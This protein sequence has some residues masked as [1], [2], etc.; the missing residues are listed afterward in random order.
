MKL[1]KYIKK[2]LLWIN[3]LLAVAILI[4][5]LA[6]FISPSRI[7]QIAFFGLA[8]PVLLLLNIGCI[9]FWSWKKKIF[10]LISLIVILAGWANVGRYLQIRI[11]N[12]SPESGKVVR[13]L[14]YNVRVFNRFILKEEFSLLDSVLWF[15]YEQGTEI[16]CL[17]EFYTENAHKEQSEE[18]IDSILYRM[19]Y[20]HISYTY[21]P[22]ATSNYG[23]ATYSRFPIIK[24][25]ILKFNNSNNSCLYSDL[26]IYE[27]TIRIYNAHLQSISLKKNDYNFVDS[28]VFRFNANRIDEIKDISGRLKHAFIKRAE[29]VDVLSNHI[30]L[31]PYPVI[32]CGDFNDTPVS[33]TYQKIKG[34][35]RDAFIK[36]GRGIG[37]TYRGNFPSFRIDFIFHSRNILSA[38]YQTHRINLSDHYPVSC[39]LWME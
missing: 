31:S 3:L 5:Y 16:L 10:V 38:D 9:I 29:Q 18:Y 34:N 22:T 12:K 33:Y 21:R 17:Q 13:L 2:I 19:P 4:A 35:L 8:Y 39:N 24:R 25:G 27:D 20:K 11:F 36:S 26:V 14:S 30:R 23:L 37:N 7:W 15:V 28:L 6:N 1:K 32:V